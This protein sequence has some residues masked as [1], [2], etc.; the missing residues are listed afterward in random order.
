MEQIEH[1][2]R[3]IHFVKFCPVIQSAAKYQTLRMS[4]QPK[5]QA[6]LSISMFS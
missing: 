3:T 2:Q 1:E 5:Y 6:D 4:V